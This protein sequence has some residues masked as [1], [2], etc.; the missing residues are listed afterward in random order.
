MP[1]T[2]LPLLALISLIASCLGSGL[3]AF[4][5]IKVSLARLE[6]WRDIAHEDI[7]TLRKDVNVLQDDSLVY[8]GEID[9]LYNDQGLHRAVRQRMRG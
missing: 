7:R 6:T 5:V 4:V 9:L 3:A 8:N 2:S 1:Q